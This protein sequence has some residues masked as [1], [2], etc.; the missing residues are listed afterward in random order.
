MIFAK[1]I[2]QL[3]STRP[4]WG[5]TR[6]TFGLTVSNPMFPTQRVHIHA[7]YEYDIFGF[8]GSSPHG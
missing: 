5:K 7:M 1:D 4:I 3:I 2:N 8:H 6:V